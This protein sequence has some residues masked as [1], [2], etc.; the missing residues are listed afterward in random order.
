[1]LNKVKSSKDGV[2]LIFVIGTLLIVVSLVTATLSM[3]LSHSRLTTHQVERTKAYYAGLAGLNLGCEMVRQGTW[4]KSIRCLCNAATCPAI[5]TGY[6][7]GRAADVVDSEIP[8]NVKIQIYDP[9]SSTDGIGRQIIA[10]VDYTSAY[11]Y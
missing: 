5:G 1:M 8:Y 9:G 7:N 11:S 2:V 10:S 3:I 4:V 6:C